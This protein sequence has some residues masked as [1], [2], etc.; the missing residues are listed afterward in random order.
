M[1]RYENWE[2]SWLSKH[3]RH[4]TEPSCLTSQTRLIVL[5]NQI[6]VDWLNEG[7][8]D[9]DR[10]NNQC[11]LHGMWL[12]KSFLLHMRPK[13]CVPGLLTGSIWAGEV[14]V[15]MWSIH[16]KDLGMNPSS[17]ITSYIFKA[18]NYVSKLQFF[19]ITYVLQPLWRRLILSFM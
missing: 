17:F 1:L 14:K 7:K 12:S 9:K 8:K 19:E 13:C 4:D 3:W 2:V 15:G 10:E 18:S 16:L 11:Y 6:F 5:W